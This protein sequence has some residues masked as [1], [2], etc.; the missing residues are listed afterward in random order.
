MTASNLQE[1]NRAKLN[2][3]TAQM[4]WRD[5]QRYFASGVALYVA[6]ELDLVEVGLQMSE[7]NAAQIQQWMAAGQFGKVSDEQAAEWFKADV[8]LWTV[9]VSPWVLV[10]P[11]K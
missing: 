3:E 10:Q 11:V 8:M 6:P 2:L 7:D 1:V 4:A 5:M 9:V